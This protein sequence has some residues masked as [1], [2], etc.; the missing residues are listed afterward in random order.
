[1]FVPTPIGNLRDITLRALDTLRACEFVVAEDTRTLRRLLNALDLP[2]KRA[3]SYR[4]QNAGAVTASILERARGAL[5]AVVT[6]AGMPGISDP[7]RELIVAA[8]AAGIA[9]EVL[10]GPSAFVC[11]AVL[12]GFPLAGFSFEGFVPR[13]EGERR[14]AL[15]EALQRRT[16][17][18]WYEAPARIGATLEAIVRL[19]P[20]AEIFLAR[21]LSKRFEQHVFGTAAVVRAALA[22]PVRGEIVFVIGAAAALERPDGKNGDAVDLAAAI[23]AELAS[24]AAPADAAKR[25]ARRFGGERAA[26]YRCIAARKNEG[27]I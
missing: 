9:V 23:D 26:I 1:M 4:E 21:E 17:S 14:R 8:R 12:S 5:V 16:P 6:D 20:V 7:G 18:V 25:L 10:P 2:S 11:A 15:G 3:V 24:G 19:N 22:T 13:R 27:R